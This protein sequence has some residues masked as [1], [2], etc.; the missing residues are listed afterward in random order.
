MRI[1]LIG[2]TISLFTNA[3]V[4]GS[5]G[6]PDDGPGLSNPN[7]IL[8]E[9]CEE[10]INLSENK[11]NIINSYLK[12][13]FISKDSKLNGLENLEMLSFILSIRL[14]NHEELDPSLSLHGISCNKDKILNFEF[15][16][17]ELRKNIKEH[18]DSLKAL[19]QSCPEWYWDDKSE[20]QEIKL[21][22]YRKEIL[23]IKGILNER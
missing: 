18:E 19:E 3:Q 17:E 7:L 1:I 5:G 6:L 14:L 22:A 8:S 16:K 4:I 15:N 11:L 23:K 12:D 13:N 10:N 9:K 20:N 21:N 2:L